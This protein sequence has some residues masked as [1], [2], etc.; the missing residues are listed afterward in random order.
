M[1]IELVARDVVVN[2]EVQKRVEE[3][4]GKI[5]ERAHQ[6]T[7]VRVTLENEAGLFS[8]LINMG[9]KGKDIVSQSQNES[10]LAA[11]DEAISKTERQ[12]KKHQD[13]LRARGR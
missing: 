1:N 11:I 4:L 6:D 12:F 9:V 7:G 5:L 10:M 3:K 8:A 2:D 13:K